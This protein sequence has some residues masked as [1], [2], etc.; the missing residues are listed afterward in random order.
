MKNSNI[1][2]SVIIVLCIAGGVSAYNITNPESNILSLPGFTPTD[3]GDTGDTGDNAGL[4]SD[5]VNTDSGSSG[6]S[7]SSGGSSNAGSSNAGGGSNTQNQ[8][9]MTA[10]QAKQ[11]IS[12]AIGQ[13]GAYAGT[14]RWDGSI[15]MWVAKIYDKNGTVVDSIG[16]D[17]NGRTNRV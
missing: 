5:S 1:I 17:A 13:E 2:I 7:G 3:S 14:P 9:G 4:N 6:V 16:V 8:N 15:K 10:S 11:I 12:G